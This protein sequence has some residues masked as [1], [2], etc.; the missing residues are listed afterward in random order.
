M[1]PSELQYNHESFLFVVVLWRNTA[2]ELLLNIESAMLRTT[3][4]LATTAMFA[5]RILS[6]HSVRLLEV[7]QQG[8]LSRGTK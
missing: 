6:K 3:V 4:S 5:L 7:S 1:E 8:S 2:E